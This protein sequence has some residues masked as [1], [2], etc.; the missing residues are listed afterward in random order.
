MAALPLLVAAS[1]SFLPFLAPKAPAAAA[2][3]RDCLIAGVRDAETIEPLADACAALRV[4]FRANLLGDGELWRAVSIVR[5]ATPRWEKS[6]RFLPFLSNRAGQAYALGGS[7]GGG[8]VVNYGEVLGR[9]FYFK[10]EGT[11]TPAA[12]ASTWDTRCPRDFDVAI[13][14]GGFVF[15]GRP[16]VSSAISG[17]GYLRCLYLD[18]DIRIFQSPGDSPD[19]WEEAGLVVVQVRDRLFADPVEGEL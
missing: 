6:A 12:S 17:P 3:L 16:F 19:K 13:R 11:F 8:S 2:E 14:E 9:S 10:A 4:P 15:G 7:N 18:E 5:G 1:A